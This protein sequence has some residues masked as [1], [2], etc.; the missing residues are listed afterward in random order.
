VGIGNSDNLRAGEKVYAIGTPTG[1]E[2]TVSEGIISNPN[3][4]FGG[5]QFIQFTAAISPGSSGGGLFDESGKVIGITTQ[6]INV[7]NGPEAGL[8]QNLNFAVPINVM[9]TVL[10]SKQTTY[11][12]SASYYYLQG[13]IADRQKD[14]DRAIENYSKAIELDS[15][16]VDAYIDLGGVYFTKGNYQ[17]ELQN[18]ISAT[19]VDPNNCDAFHYLATA[20]EDVGQYDKAFEAFKRAL[21]IDPENKDVLHDYAILCLAAGDKDDATLLVDRLTELN[22]GWGKVLHA[23]LRREK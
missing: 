3:R 1:Q 6:T 18:Y 21:T 9:K 4:E 12:G 16:Y 15:S 22:P 11:Q 8:A 10:S 17:L 19:E 20:Y 23:I 13:T 5:Q 7:R 14:W 2:G